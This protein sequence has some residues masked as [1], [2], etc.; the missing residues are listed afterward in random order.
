MTG[1][2]GLGKSRRTVGGGFKTD[3]AL[4]APP[5]FSN[6]IDFVGLGKIFYEFIGFFIY[7]ERSRRNFDDEIITFF[8]GLS[9]SL[10]VGTVWGLKLPFESKRI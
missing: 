9:L 7:D 8:A 4:A 6:D 5:A 2:T 10:A 3:V 1:F